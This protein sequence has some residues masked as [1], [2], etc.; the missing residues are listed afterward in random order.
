MLS[1]E[2]ANGDYP[3]E[4]VREMRKIIV[5]T[6]NNISVENPIE[7]LVKPNHENRQVVKNYSINLKNFKQL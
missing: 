4:T 1:D 7:K 2:T 3:I 5:Y 6:Q